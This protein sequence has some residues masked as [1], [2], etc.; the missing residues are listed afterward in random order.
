MQMPSPAALLRVPKTAMNH[1]HERYQ[2][3][4]YSTKVM[5]VHDGLGYRWKVQVQFIKDLI[6][7]H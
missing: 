6:I 7:F 2:L 4:A 5:A 3:I 1:H